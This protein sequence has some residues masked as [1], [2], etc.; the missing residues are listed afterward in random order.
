MTTTDVLAFP[1]MTRSDT[2]S[3]IKSSSVGPFE[4]DCEN[5]AFAE[6]FP[7]GV[8][9]LRTCKAITGLQPR[10]TRMKDA[11][12]KSLAAEWLRARTG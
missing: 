8:A 12:T 11:M 6:E 7:E 5:E 2:L 10:V 1:R 4:S 3:E 9:R